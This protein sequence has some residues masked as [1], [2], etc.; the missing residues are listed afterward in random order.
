M[1][2]VAVT[3][4]KALGTSVHVL[5]TDPGELAAAEMAVHETLSEVD[6]AYS[7][8]RSDS[9]LSRLNAA[10]GRPVRVSP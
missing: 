4:S 1:M 5:T 7:R 2:S 9:E 3:S 6:Q 10:A 8:F